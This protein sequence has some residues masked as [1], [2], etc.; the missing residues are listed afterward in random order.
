[1]E[2][3]LTAA[4]LALPVLYA[5][6]AVLYGRHFLDESGG[7]EFEG[8]TLL[9]GT[10]AFHALYLTALGLHG[11]HFPVATASEF[12]CLLA[13]SVGVTYSIAE[14]WHRDANT[15][16]FFVGIVFVFQLASTAM[17]GDPGSVPDRLR[18]P[19]FGIHVVLTVFGFAGLTVSS[20]Y[21]LMYLLLNRQLKSRQLGLVF[22][23]LP[24]LSTLEKMSKVATT[25]G[26]LLLGLGLALGHWVAFRRFTA[27]E[28]FQQ[29]LIV[30]A[31]VAWV[32]YLAGLLLARTRRL[33]GVRFGYAS[34]GGYL[35]FMTS[36]VV[37]LAT[38]GTFHTFP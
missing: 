5:A 29:P 36:L 16:L 37:V 32:G 35:A 21:S 15:G 20:L 19:I 1:M 3:A 31:D 25:S 17:S 10:L 4:N 9:Y 33:T 2:L 26:V 34:L 12:F 28:L 22:R 7:V 18:N 30:I 27:L 8:P 14:R 13:L 23:Q 6:C 11:L 24:P 38:A